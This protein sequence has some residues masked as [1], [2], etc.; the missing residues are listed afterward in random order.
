LVNGINLQSGLNSVQIGAVSDITS[1][2]SGVFG[3]LNLGTF[4]SSSS[5]VVQMLNNLSSTNLNSLGIITSRNINTNNS[6]IISGNLEKT[7]GKGVNGLSISSNVN[8]VSLYVGRQ[9]TQNSLTSIINGLNVTSSFGIS[10]NLIVNNLSNFG[11]NISKPLQQNITVNGYVYNVEPLNAKIQELTGVSG[12][13]SQ[14]YLNQDRTL[15]I[16]SN[17]IINEL[18]I[19]DANLVFGLSSEN[20]ISTIN[21]L[22]GLFIGV[23]VRSNI[24]N[25]R[26]SGFYNSKQFLKILSM[27]IYFNSVEDNKLNF[28]NIITK[29]GTF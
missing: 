10:S 21:D 14:G 1:P 13:L 18:G 7:V 11:K 28:N 22:E 17:S 3:I 5:S 29:R 26:I 23:T 25:S 12:A 15:S 2:V 6:N 24:I 19:I 9:I 16:G 27:M 4:V 20:L 8:G